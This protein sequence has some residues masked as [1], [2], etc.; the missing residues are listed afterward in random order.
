V[1]DGISVRSGVEELV[2]M[3]GEDGSRDNAGR[4]SLSLEKGQDVLQFG[5]FWLCRVSKSVYDV[6][7][8]GV[9]E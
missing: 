6:N 9:A 2:S 1:E 7:V 8:Y 4:L 5:Q 3:R